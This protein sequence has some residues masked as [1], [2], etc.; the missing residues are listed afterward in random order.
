MDQDRSWQVIEEQRLA[1]AGLLDGLTPEQWEA[2]SLCAGWR[3]RDVAAHVS[4]VALPPSAGSMLGD[5]VRARGSFHVLNTLA[6]R[7]R[8]ERSPAQLVA[9][10]RDHAASRKIPVV[11]NQRNVLFD[12]MAHGQDI[13][14][15]LGLDLPLP[16]DAA[17]AGA[18]RV[19][20]MGWPF[21]AKRR[22]RGL[23]LVATDVEWSVGSGAEV[24]GP[25]RAM[26]LLVTGR[27]STATPLLTGKGV[28][29]LTAMTTSP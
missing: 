29:R 19:W 23:H 22:L 8:A 17:A 15:P 26:L 28:E 14:I 2:P 5:L 9:D 25:I 24:R 13:A 12:V 10:L 16:P 21:W 11:S 27:T 4:L 7:R 1:I 3:V 6:T 18:T 20:E